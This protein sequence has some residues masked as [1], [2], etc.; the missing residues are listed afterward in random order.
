MNFYYWGILFSLLKVVGILAVFNEED[1]I[2]EWINH[3]LKQGLQL[4]I[5]DGGSTD[6][7]FEKCEQF[8]DDDKV[9]L[10]QIRRGKNLALD[11]RSKYDLALLE[12][13]DWIVHM[14]ADEFF[15]SGLKNLNLKE[16]IEEEDKKGYNII[17]FNRFEFFITDGD[18]S[19]NSVMKRQPYY[20]FETDF[21]Y[22]AW[23]FYPGIYLEPTG[24]HLPI[25]PPEYKY[26]LSPTRMI[27][28]HYRFRN[29]NQ[30][31]LKLQTR[32][33]RAK[34][35]TETKIGWHVHNKKILE[36][37]KSFIV[38]HK[39]LTKYNEDNNWNKQKKFSYFL[40]KHGTR[41]ELFSEDGKLKNPHLTYNELK[42][43]L[44]NQ[45]K[46]INDLK[47][48]LKSSSS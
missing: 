4:V 9:K 43:Q 14:D 38:N 17:Q 30:A 37:N 16:A 15:E 6:S 23:K 36:E 39:L 47:E 18:S 3:S 24:G 42:L 11:L 26:K 35:I 31:R 27:I 5:L 20:S 44:I 2:E 34:N 25:F 45:E 1:I 32:L 29:E 7:T 48:K 10:F 46:I 22:R 13:P 33:E 40:I 28:R 19:N 21:V 12:S 41:E 8:V